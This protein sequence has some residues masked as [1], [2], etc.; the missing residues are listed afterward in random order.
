MHVRPSLS[1]A[2]HSACDDSC[3]AALS[4]ALLYRCPTRLIKQLARTATTV[5]QQH[6]THSFAL[7]PKHTNSCSRLVAPWDL[8][9]C[10][11]TTHTSPCACT[12]SCCCPWPV[13]PPDPDGE[14]AGK[15]HPADVGPHE[16]QGPRGADVLREL[17]HSGDDGPQHGCKGGRSTASGWSVMH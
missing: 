13:V 8:L 11:I 12:S 6:P 4:T 17:H 9:I 14:A 1:Q 10:N 15:G 5:T 16:Q 2:S 7:S 3:A